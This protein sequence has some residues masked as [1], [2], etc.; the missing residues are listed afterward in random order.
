MTDE[1]SR[2]SVVARNLVLAEA[3]DEILRSGDEVHG[4]KWACKRAI[5]GFRSTDAM[6]L[7]SLALPRIEARWPGRVIELTC[8]D[9]AASGAR[10]YLI[11]HEAPSIKRWIF[12]DVTLLYISQCSGDPPV[13]FSMND[14][15][16]RALRAAL[17]TLLVRRRRCYTFEEYDDD[18]I[19]EQFGEETESV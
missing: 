16:Q 13:F 8:D 7:M 3:F 2:G 17:Q 4:P 9:D 19:G 10:L 6:A 18:E 12:G 11:T 14:D 5:D 1:A 15:E